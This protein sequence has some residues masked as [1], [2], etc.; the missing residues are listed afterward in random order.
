MSACMHVCAC[1]CA[2]AFARMSVHVQPCAH[3]SLCVRVCMC[4]CVCIHVSMSALRRML[5]LPE[6]GGIMIIQRNVR[7]TCLALEILVRVVPLFYCPIKFMK[8]MKAL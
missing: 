4:V 1:T 6:T 2:C 5:E 3:A 8:F 7:N